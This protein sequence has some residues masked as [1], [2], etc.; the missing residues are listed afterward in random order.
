MT[1]YVSRVLNAAEITHLE[2]LVVMWALKHFKD[3]VLG[4]P[5]TIYIDHA[6]VT[7]LFKGK[8]MMGRF[9][10]KVIYALESGDETSLRLL[11][12]SFS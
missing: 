2:T 12:V 1:A 7:E 6:A 3:I 10:A 4:Y 11:P 9:W 8:S 5:V